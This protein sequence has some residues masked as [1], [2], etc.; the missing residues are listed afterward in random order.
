MKKKIKKI[1]SDKPGPPF[2]LTPEEEMDFVKVLIVAS[3][4]GAPLTQLDL[5]LVVYNYLKKNNK[6]DV[7]DDKLP[8]EWWVKNFIERHRDQL[9]MR[10]IQNIKRA[11]AEKTVSEF[12]Q[13]FSNLESVLENVPPTHVIN[14]D[15]TNFSD[16]P[17]SV[18][19][20]CRRG[21]KYPERVMNSSKGCISVMFAATGNGEI[22]PPYVV[23]KAESLWQQ[24]VEG[25]PENARFNRTKSGWFDAVT[26]NDWFNTIIV[27]WARK[28]V[29]P[30]VVIGDNLSSHINVEVIKL[31]EKYEIRFVL[32][33]PNS[34]H[35]T[36]PLDVAFFGPLKKVWRKILTT[37][38]YE[39][40]MQT[41]LNKCHF[42][43]LLAKVMD[44]VNMKKK[45]NIV[46]GFRATG[47]IPFNP[48]KVYKRIPESLP[49]EPNYTVDHTLLE[50]LKENRRPNEMKRGRNKKLNVEP[51]KSIT[52]SDL[53]ENQKNNTKQI[54]PNPKN[55]ALKPKEENLNK[56]TAENTKNL[57]KQTNQNTKK[58]SL[59]TEEENFNELTS[60]GNRS[61]DIMIEGC[62]ENKINIRVNICGNLSDDDEASYN[63]DSV[64]HDVATLK[65][66]LFQK[67]N[68]KKQAAT[69]LKKYLSGSSTT[70]NTTEWSE[71]SDNDIELIE[72]E[73]FEDD[74]I[75]NDAK[76][77]VR[78]IEEEIFEEIA[79]IDK[80]DNE[81]INDKTETNKQEDENKKQ[82]ETVKNLDIKDE[83][84]TSKLED[85]KEKQ[86]KKEK[87]EGTGKN[88]DIKDETETNK[89][90]DENEKQE[91]KDQR[92]G[93]DTNLDEKD[94]TKSNKLE[95]EKTKKHE[96]EWNKGDT[97]LTRYYSRK[98]KYFIGI[99]KDI[100]RY[101]KTY[102]VSYYKLIHNK[103]GNKFILP[104]KSDEDK[105]LPENSIVKSV[106]LLQISENPNEYVVMNDEDNIY[107]D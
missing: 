99:I 58:L 52:T 45:E 42:P 18:K 22:M 39:N 61:S 25:G 87:Q 84:E 1:H 28:M 41:G 90:E 76:M 21:M 26:F 62:N 24:W 16:D 55:H 37:Y 102:T 82:E 104:K 44:E 59:K 34:T 5:R 106:E 100:N 29:G 83:T 94:V 68:C 88:L 27:P 75:D 31:S 32:L 6:G 93:T 64:K 81:D 49:D 50:Y 63:E 43:P 91:K 107:F 101:N 56:I 97:I 98:W 40:P 35:L 30:K 79:K 73:D 20:I 66:N 36:Q 69:R 53:S 46:S 48:Q 92:E 85:E 9:S 103:K 33:P 65:R 72:L 10:A 71:Y 12:E 51:G 4:Y 2:R 15:E 60:E 80:Q 54:K 57:K 11:R 105:F 77:R 38:K 13:Y 8:G 89:L 14:Y 3:E 74:Y 67:E 96:M 23:Y 47:I 95:D 19:C 86:E 78:M 7:F 70:E 17:G